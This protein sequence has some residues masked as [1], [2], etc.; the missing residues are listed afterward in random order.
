MGWL[1]INWE[2]IQN[3]ILLSLKFGICTNYNK[4]DSL[5]ECTIYLLFRIVVGIEK[6]DWRDH[7]CLHMFTFTLYTH[8]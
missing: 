2:N 6:V 8:S 5:K 7:K 4:I 3:K 1:K